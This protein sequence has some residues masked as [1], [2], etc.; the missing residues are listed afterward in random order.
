MTQESS[1]KLQR[2]YS[3]EEIKALDLNHI[4][5]HVA[6]IPDGNRRWA[7]QATKQTADGHK[8]GTGVVTDIVQAA[9]ELGIKVLTFFTFSTENWS[10]SEHEVKFLMQLLEKNLEDALPKMLAQGVRFSTIGDLS[11]LPPELIEKIKVAK[12]KTASGNR[13]ELVLATNYG[14]RDDLK[15]AVQKIGLAC[16]EGRIDPQA[17]DEKLISHTLDTA[18]WPDPDL[19]IRTSGESRISNFLLWQLSYSELYFTN[20]LWPEFTPQSFYDA[21]QSYQTRLRRMGG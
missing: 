9:A 21:I 2:I 20:Q 6:I 7:Q 8:R 19:L 14:G 10:R 13:L 15:R 4:P 17:I 16:K 1:L 3:D 5:K 12:E 18:P 11:A